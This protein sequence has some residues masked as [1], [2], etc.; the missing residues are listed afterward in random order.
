MSSENSTENSTTEG[1]NIAGYRN[2]NPNMIY[3]LERSCLANHKAGYDQHI[4]PSM[5]AENFLSISF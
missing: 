2:L 4:S 3:C 5:R 1:I